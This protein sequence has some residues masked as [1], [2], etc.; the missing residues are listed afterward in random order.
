MPIIYKIL[1]INTVRSSISLQIILIA[2]AANCCELLR[3]KDFFLRALRNNASAMTAVLLAAV[4]GREVTT[5]DDLLSTY[6]I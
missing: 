4:T 1:S 5:S 2:S 3:K 6:K